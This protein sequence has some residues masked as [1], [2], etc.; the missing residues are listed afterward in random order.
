VKRHPHIV[1]LLDHWTDPATKQLC[2]VM[3]YAA[4]GDLTTHVAALK[5]AGKWSITSALRLLHG[6]ARGLEYAHEQGI[7]HRD[8]KPD[9]VLVSS[10]GRAMLGDFGLARD[11]TLEASS[12]WSMSKGV[13]TPLW[14]ALE[15]LRNKPYT[16]TADVW[17]VGLIGFQLLVGEFSLRSWPFSDPSGDPITDILALGMCLMTRTPDWSR[18]PADTPAAVKVLLAAMLHKDPPARPSARRVTGI[19]SVVVDDLEAALRD[20]PR[21]PRVL[22]EVGVSAAAGE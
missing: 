12:G 7:W 17:S 11:T 10:D 22:V 14:M 18:L 13:G 6:I 3:E 8:I 1:S 19:L 21:E 5:T 4:G 2:L 16:A 15:V 9:N 20:G